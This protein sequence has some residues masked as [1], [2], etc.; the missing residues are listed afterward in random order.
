MTIGLD[1]EKEKVKDLK[2]INNYFAFKLAT[3]LRDEEENFVPKKTTI[4]RKVQIYLD[5]QTV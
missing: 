2:N 3:V 4:N 1:Y 5:L